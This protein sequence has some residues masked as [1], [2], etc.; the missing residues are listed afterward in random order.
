MDLHVALVQPIAY[1]VQ[2]ASQVPH[3]NV[4]VHAHDGA[5]Q[6]CPDALDGIGV[7]VAAHELLGLMPH[8]EI[9]G[10]TDEIGCYDPN[11]CQKVDCSK[12]EFPS[13]VRLP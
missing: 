11:V 5:F 6:K 2:T 1:F 8:G 10:D 7:D 13:W 12:G 4:V 3:G 9:G